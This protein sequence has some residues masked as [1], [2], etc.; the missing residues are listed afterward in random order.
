MLHDRD[1][2]RGSPDRAQ[3]PSNVQPKQKTILRNAV[4]GVARRA[5]TQSSHREP[6]QRHLVRLFS[7]A[8]A[9]FVSLTTGSDEKPPH[10]FSAV[11][12][13]FVS[14]CT[15]PG[16]LPPAGSQGWNL[17]CCQKPVQG[18]HD[19]SIGN[20]RHNTSKKTHYGPGSMVAVQLETL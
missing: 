6:P 19:G 15:K 1:A 20:T 9:S 5:P 3:L 4:A 2:S 18:I 16:W 7:V 12:L 13:R 10:L 17:N 8:T 11:T 14:L